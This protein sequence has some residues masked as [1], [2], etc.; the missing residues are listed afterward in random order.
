MRRMA[1]VAAVVFGV[2][3]LAVGLASV[4]IDDLLHQTGPGGPVADWLATAVPMVSAAAV[5]TLVA[6]RR[7]SNPIGWMLLAIFLFAAAPTGGYAILD[8][9]MHHGT[10]PFG[11]VAVVFHVAWPMFLVLVTT[12]LW[13]FPDGRLPPGRWRGLARVLVVVW[14]LVGLVAS[15]RGV[16]AAAGHDIR[17]DAGGN[18]TAD[19]PGPWRI[20][21]AVVIVG[22]LASGL[23]W[24]IVQVPRYRRSV[25]ERRQ[26]LKWLYTGAIVFVI[27]TFLPGQVGNDVIGPLGA[28]AL[29]VCIGVA[30]LKYRLFEIDRIIS[31]V[32]SYAIITAVLAGVFA[33][34]V[35][36]AT[37]VLPFRAP[38]A[39]AAATLAVAALFN[40]LRR[41]V[42]RAVDRRFNRARYNAEAVVAAFTARLRQTVDLDTVQDDLVGTVSLAFQPAHVSVWLQWDQR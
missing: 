8:Y 12:L 35:V 36:L 13:L 28:A 27:S 21:L 32:I 5:G 23:T 39:V 11:W 15:A 26:Q 40:P 25:G 7:P 22:S 16:A 31:R 38:A 10:L 24:L 33:G 9:R 18:L 14:V 4:P 19:Q 41:R 17:I 2:L 3:T 42:Q 6:A 20:S 1:A 30:V 29:P 34:L 37:E